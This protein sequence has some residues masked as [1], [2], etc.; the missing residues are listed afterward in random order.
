MKDTIVLAGLVMVMLFAYTTAATIV[1]GA[2][3]QSVVSCYFDNQYRLIKRIADEEIRP[4]IAG[5]GYFSRKE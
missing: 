4:P 5:G 3:M 2:V 1:I